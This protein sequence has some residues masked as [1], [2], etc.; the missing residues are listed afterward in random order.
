M[1]TDT[2]LIGI[3]DTDTLESTGT[4]RMARDLRDHLINLNMGASLGV[5]RHQL[6]VDDRIPYTLHNSSHL[7]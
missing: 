3:D 5:S 6:L 4:G 1:Q 2:I 7:L